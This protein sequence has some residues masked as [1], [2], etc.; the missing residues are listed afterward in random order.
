MADLNKLLARPGFP[1][2][3]SE[4]Y[5]EEFLDATCEMSKSAGGTFLQRIDVY[6]QIAV[7]ELAARSSRRNST[8]S[9]LIS[10]VALTISIGVSLWTS[11]SSDIR[12]KHWEENQLKILEEIRNGLRQPCL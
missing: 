3:W 6:I 9:L 5:L 4:K 1:S 12:S 8:A 2:K 7:N 10:L 11:Y